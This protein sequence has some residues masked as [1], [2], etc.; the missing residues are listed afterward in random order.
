MRSRGEEDDWGWGELTSCSNCTDY[1]A[2]RLNI[3]HKTRETKTQYA[4]TVNGTGITTR[5]LIPLMEQNQQVDG[6][7]LLPPV[8]QALMGG[9]K[10]LNG[11]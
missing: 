3:R 7:I 9:K 11:N 2:R 8:L 4:H 1:Q 10:Y 5:A 6:S